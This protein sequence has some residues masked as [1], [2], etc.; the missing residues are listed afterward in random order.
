VLDKEYVRRKVLELGK[1]NPRKD[2]VVTETG[3]YQEFNLNGIVTV[4][5][6]L[7]DQSTVDAIFR[8]VPDMRGK[9]VLDIG[10]NAGLRSVSC[11]IKGAHVMSIEHRPWYVKQAEFV[12]E[13]YEDLCGRL[14]WSIVQIDIL[15][16]DITKLGRFNLILMINLMKYMTSEAEENL[17]E[18]KLDAI[19][20]ISTMSN[21][22]VATLQRHKH[23]EYLTETCGFTLR[24][25]TRSN[26]LRFGLFEK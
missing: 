3:W 20:K 6:D 7:A 23:S 24:K 9:T 12:R 22:I 16:G 4:E 25:Y 5:N 19:S 18:L 21:S 8:L 11:A 26:V 13:F 17:E 2:G 14:D 10:S 15:T 1:L